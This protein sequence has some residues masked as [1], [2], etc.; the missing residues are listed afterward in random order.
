MPT[1]RN[2]QSVAPAGPERLRSLIGRASLADIS[3]TER[4]MCRAVL[5]GIAEWTE[6][7]TGLSRPGLE[8]LKI[9]TGYPETC[10]HAAAELLEAAGLLHVR[11]GAE[12][13]AAEADVY[14]LNVERLAVD[15]ATESPRSARVIA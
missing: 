14:A 12:P 1:T 10:I 15:T 5:W 7:E 6:P 11:T 3:P 4:G 13:A 9:E 8:H 2:S